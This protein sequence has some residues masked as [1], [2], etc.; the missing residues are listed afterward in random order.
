MAWK[1]TV[2]FYLVRHG[3]SQANAD[4]S[5]YTKVPDQQIE[6]TEHGWQ[7]AAAT[8]A[9]LAQH[10]RRKGEKRPLMLRTSG[11]MRARQTSQCLYNALTDAGF[12]VHVR[13][14]DMLT[15][16]SLGQVAGRPRAEWGKEHPAYAALFDMAKEKGALHF[17]VPP[18]GEARLATELRV[19]TDLASIHRYHDSHGRGPVILVNHGETSR[20]I[21]KVL[22]GQR[23]EDSDAE[24]PFGNADVRLIARP[25]G[26]GLLFALL[27]RSP[28][29]LLDYG[30][31]WKDGVAH[32]PAAQARTRTT[33]LFR[34]NAYGRTP[35]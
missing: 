13:E 26:P 34:N 22:L 20:Q 33:D 4:K 28:Y 19:R 17:L 3:Q 15:E 30:F 32:P 25:P 23:H 12:T 29:P 24:P 16:Q 9:F 21:A 5:L 8:G 14:S 6:L 7:Q 31:I 2:E 11:H 10:F 35:E 27:G 1:E 18:G